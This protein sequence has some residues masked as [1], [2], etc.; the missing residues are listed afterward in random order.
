MGLPLTQRAF[1]LYLFQ[2]L[3]PKLLYYLTPP[4]YSNATTPLCKSLMVLGTK[5]KENQDPSFKIDFRQEG[6]RNVCTSS[7]NE[8]AHKYISNK[9]VCILIVSTR[10]DSNVSHFFSPSVNL[11]S[12]QALLV[13]LFV[14][15]HTLTSLN[16]VRIHPGFC[17]DCVHSSSAASDVT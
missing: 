10:S 4:Q 9:K 16:L 5:K 17:Q 14:S 3:W 6:R 15:N 1:T 11:P 12:P 8:Y 7:V 2:V 13:R